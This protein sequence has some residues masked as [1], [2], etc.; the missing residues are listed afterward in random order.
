MK[1][2][3]K[4]T[5]IVLL[6]SISSCKKDKEPVAPLQDPL[7]GYMS[8]TGFSQKIVN[9]VNNGVY[10]FGYSFKPLVNG[11]MT[12][13]VVKIP[14]VRSGLRV[15]VWDKSAGSVLRTEVVD[16]PTAGVEVV[17]NIPALDL[18][19]GKE[20]FLTFNSD[21]WYDNRR[22]DNANA[23]YPITVGDISITSYGYSSGTSQTMPTNMPLNYYAGNCSFKF[24][25]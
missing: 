17:K 9:A 18:V 4:L 3:I 24:Q 6:L 7:N 22:T 11:Q 14:D 12:A 13:L 15:T 16:V 10:E 20:Y 23:V 2:I 5:S 1:K 8:A 19:S 21:D 25:K